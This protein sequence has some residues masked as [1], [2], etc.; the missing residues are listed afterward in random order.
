M[1]AT[2][3]ESVLRYRVTNADR[4]SLSHGTIKVGDI[5]FPGRDGY[6][7]AN[8]DTRNFGFE[9]GAFSLNPSGEPFFTMPKADVE[10]VP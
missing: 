5:V 1:S 4:S 8:D 10:R 7:C 3:Q 2:G 9:F 6:G